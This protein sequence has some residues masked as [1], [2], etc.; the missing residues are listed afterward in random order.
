[1]SDLLAIDP[2]T[3]TGWSM[4]TDGQ[5]RASGHCDFTPRRN[6]S[7][8]MRLIRFG[9]WLREMYTPDLQVIA[10]EEVKRHAGT[11]AAHIYGA[12]VG[13]LQVFCLRHHVELMAVP[14]AQWK[15]ELG[16]KGN[17][18]KQE[19]RALVD[20]RWPNAICTSDDEADAIGIGFCAVRVVAGV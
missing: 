19:I 8:G 14:I 1:M 3:H 13:I 2:G 4:W 9:A 6:E 20:E 5:F 7:S 12:L 18:K 10:V 16:L 17:A 15:R 11:D